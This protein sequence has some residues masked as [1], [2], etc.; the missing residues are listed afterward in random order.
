MIIFVYL[1][2]LKFVFSLFRTFNFSRDERVQNRL[3]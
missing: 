2:V 3:L 1:K